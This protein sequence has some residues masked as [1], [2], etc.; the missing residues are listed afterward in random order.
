MSSQK[1]K[2]TNPAEEELAATESLAIKRTSIPT[3]QME[4]D[5]SEVI[6]EVFKARR[7]LFKTTEKNERIP[8]GYLL[9][10]HMFYTCYIEHC[11]KTNTKVETQAVIDTAWS[12][13]LKSGKI[14]VYN[15]EA[16]D[17]DLFFGKDN[18]LNFTYPQINRILRGAEMRNREVIFEN[19]KNDKAKAR[20]YILNT[21]PRNLLIEAIER[22]T[23]K[24]VTAEVMAKSGKYSKETISEFMRQDPGEYLEPFSEYQPLYRPYDPFELRLYSKDIV[25]YLEGRLERVCDCGYRMFSVMT[26]EVGEEAM[27]EKAATESVLPPETSSM[28][29]VETALKYMDDVSTIVSILNERP[30]QETP[31]S[32]QK[33]SLKNNGGLIGIKGMIEVD[34]LIHLKTRIAHYYSENERTFERSKS[35]RSLNE[36]NNDLPPVPVDRDGYNRV[37]K[38]LENELKCP[39]CGKLLVK[40]GFF[41]PDNF[42]SRFVDAV[43]EGTPPVFVGHPGDGK[44]T[45]AE[46][47]LRYVQWRYGTPYKTYMVSEA[48]S[49]GVLLGRLNITAMLSKSRDKEGQDE[50]E[51]ANVLYGIVSLCLFRKDWRG[52][53]GA[54]LMLDEFNRCEF[55]HIAFFMSFLASP[56]RFMIDDDNYRQ[57]DYPNR[58][59]NASWLLVCTMNTQ[60]VNNES[61]SIAAKSRFSFID[62]EYNEQEKREIIQRQ[63]HLDSPTHSIINYL[64]DIWSFTD[65]FREGGVV[66]FPAGIRHLIRIHEVL[67][68]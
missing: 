65:G 10:E 2:A 64:M 9:K 43:E 1:G 37:Q 26:T 7:V 59:G 18:P 38:S 21:S 32:E 66:R 42:V 51:A 53:Y 62:V 6:L 67:K 57:V 31:V 25:M 39:K 27:P 63:F 30:L 45:M 22:V 15:E 54:N 24:Y 55:K 60:D 16:H 19:V 12:K 29:P 41:K 47:I 20:I 35:V 4:R 68:K 17:S 33:K 14:I 40:M 34:Q 36:I 52:G 11:A 3:V 50:R 48:T 23:A 28:G 44:S 5:T 8:K 58:R 49:S 61:I 56:Y 46:W 13:L